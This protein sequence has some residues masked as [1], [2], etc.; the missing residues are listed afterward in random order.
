[1]SELSS[2]IQRLPNKDL[3]L[4]GERGLNISGGQ[5]Q[6]IGI[7]RAIYKKPEILI[8]DESTSALDLKTEKN[9]RKFT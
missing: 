5:K 4:V 3:T 8:L 9:Y 2:F 1:M 6:R 7:A